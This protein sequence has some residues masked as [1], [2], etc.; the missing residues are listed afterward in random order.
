MVYLVED[1]IDDQEIIQAALV[2]NGY[3]GPLITLQNGK[4][5]MDRLLEDATAKPD[6]ILLDLNLPLRDGFDVLAEIKWHPL[7]RTIPVIVLTAS[8]KKADE[9][10]CLELGCNSFFTKPNSMQEYDSLVLLVKQFTGKA[11]A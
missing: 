2:Q 11:T 6:V 1:D 4:A 7:F 3:T 10:R 9:R 8:K 5:L